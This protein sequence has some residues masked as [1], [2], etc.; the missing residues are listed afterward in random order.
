MEV[1]SFQKFEEFLQGERIRKLR[2]WPILDRQ[3]VAQLRC[4]CEEL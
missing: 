2:A 3:F 4:L 1:V